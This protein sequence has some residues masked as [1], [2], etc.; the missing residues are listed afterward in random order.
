MFREFFHIGSRARSGRAR[1][2]EGRSGIRLSVFGVS[3]LT[4]LL[5][6]EAGARS[7]GETLPEP[8]EW[9]DANMQVKVEQMDRLHNEE[10]RADFVFAGT[11][12]VFRGIAPLAFDELSD[13]PTFSYNAGVLAGMPPVQRRWILEEVEPRLNPRVVVY[14][15]SSLDFQERRYKYPVNSYE[16]APATRRGFMAAAQRF[17]ARLL[18]MVR[19]RTEL[20]EPTTWAKIRRGRQEGPVERTRTRMDPRGHI[21][22]AKKKRGPAERNRMRD[23]VLR[24]YE[25][26]RRGTKQVLQ[27]VHTL[28]ERGSDVVLVS[29]PVPRGFIDV[30][31]RGERDF[32]AARRHIG[33]IADRAGVP[34]VDM[35]HSMSEGRFVD[36]THLS[37]RGAVLFSRKLRREVSRLGYR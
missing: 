16:S 6:A 23:N 10:R 4:V 37:E 29:M 36:F 17:G 25:I 1:G 32:E 26:S 5:F 15:L 28:Q 14:G 12:M 11:S 20:R 18:K 8:V 3:A 30:H 27:I 34:F 35:S 9:Y 31:P 7:V 24:D 21:F 2:R 22:K 19:L 33:R 13:R